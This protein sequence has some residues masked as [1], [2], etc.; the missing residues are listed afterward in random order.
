MPGAEDANDTITSSKE[1]WGSTSSPKYSGIQEQGK[2]WVSEEQKSDVR[3]NNKAWSRTFV[4]FFF[5]SP[6][7][8]SKQ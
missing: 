3:F 1:A 8:A 7:H 4:F 6:S 5:F 2:W